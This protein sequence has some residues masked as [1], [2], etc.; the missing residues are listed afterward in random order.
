MGLIQQRSASRG[1]HPSWSLWKS[2]LH[3]KV[4]KSSWHVLSEDALRQV[5]PGTWTTSASTQTTTTTSPTHLVCAQCIS[6]ES[7]QRT[8]VNIRWLQSTLSARRSAPLNLLLEVRFNFKC[9]FCFSRGV[10]Y[11]LS[12][13]LFFFLFL[14]HRLKCHEC[15]MKLFLSQRY[16]GK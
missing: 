5:Y 10:C 7:D 6:S 16:S 12:S 15:F 4:I 11:N 9:W 2:T 1:L 14:L 13:W 8:A 3:L